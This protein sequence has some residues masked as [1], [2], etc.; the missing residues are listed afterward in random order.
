M[1]QNVFGPNI[2]IKLDVFHALQRVTR[3]IKSGDLIV[4]KNRSR[5]TLFFR[6]VK[7]I[8]RQGDD[9]G[10]VRQRSTASAEQIQRNI[11]D[12]LLEFEGELKP[13]TVNELT[14]LRERHATCLAD[15]PPKF[16][17]NLNEALHRKINTFFRDRRVISLEKA[18][19]LLICLLATHNA[20]ITGHDPF[21]ESPDYNNATPFDF[22][23]L[24]SMGICT[25]VEKNIYCLLYTSPSPRD[26]QKS[27]MPSS[28]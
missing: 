23:N 13:N 9:N 27:R 15:I 8:V 28:A 6:H 12:L 21:E 20:N 4:D 2:A 19:S 26:R 3:T 7:L 18:L 10:D 5:R 11:D 24:A 17:T 1:L 22:T 16:G 25:N 14:K